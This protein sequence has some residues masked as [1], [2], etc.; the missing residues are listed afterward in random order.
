MKI[1]KI[2]LF[3]F[4]IFSLLIFTGCSDS[5]VSKSE[6]KYGVIYSSIDSNK[7]KLYTY[8]NDG[9]YVS[10]KDIDAGGITLSSF[11]KFGVNVGDYI[12]YGCPISENKGNNYIL[13]LNTNTLEDKKI[14]S[15]KITPT[16]FSVNDKYAYSGLST[17]TT[18]YLSKTDL[19]KNEVLNSTEIQGQGI[20]MTQ[21]DKNLYAIT[22]IHD[23]NPHGKVYILDKD[24]FKVS[25]TIDLP[26]LTFIIDAKIIDNNMYILPNRDGK[27]NLSNK[28]IKLN[29]NDFSINTIDLP[30]DNL[31]KLH[32]DDNN[33][34]VVEASYNGYET[35]NRIA[36][37]NL[38]NM[39]IDVF[40]SKNNNQTS[41]IVKDEFISS[42]G[43]KIYIYDTKNFKLIKEFKLDKVKDQKFVSF[44]IN[45]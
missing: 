29:L 17:L 32:S 39:K 37:I 24:N 4:S 43:E 3:L 36:K 10:N 33:L 26:D 44:Y 13:Q 34:Y 14:K 35:K 7:S 41:Y 28:L 8:D 12:Y 1:F 25:K 23:L 5:K 40:N 2:L 19:N 27:D 11:M 42:D 6:Y 38:Q 21:D 22:I 9:K 45:N 31:F 15:D 30:F 20:F 16:H 18:T